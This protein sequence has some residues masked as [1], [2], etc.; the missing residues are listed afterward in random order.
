[1][2]EVVKAAEWRKFAP[3]ENLITEG[4]SDQRFFIIASGL[5]KVSA[6]GQTL[7]AVRAGEPVGEMACARRGNDPR[8][9]TVTAVEA[10]WAVGLLVDDLDRFSPA[11]HA[12]FSNAFLAIMAQ[13]IAMLSGRLLHALQSEKIGMV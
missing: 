4:E 13:R 8:T 10:T 9:A 7:N 12:R 11:C 1:M 2:W 5:V 3:G 6:R